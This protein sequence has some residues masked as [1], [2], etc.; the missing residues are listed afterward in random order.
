MKVVFADHR[1]LRSVSL[2]QFPSEAWTAVA[3]GGALRGDVATVM[4]AYERVAWFQR[5]VTLRADAIARMPYR[6]TFRDGRDDMAVEEVLPGVPNF[7]HLLNVIE[8]D[9]TLFGAAYLWLDAGRPPRARQIRRMHPSAIRPRLDRDAGLVGFAHRVAGEERVYTTDEIG[10]IWLPNRRYDLGP[11]IAPAV[12]AVRAA[13]ILMALDEYV[14]RFFAQGTIS[15]MVIGVAPE[16]DETDLQRIRSWFERVGVGIRNA[17]RAIAIRGGITPVHLA[18][19]EIEKLALEE[20]HAEKRED[21]ATAFGI[22]QSILFSNAA[23]Y[24]TAQQDDLHFYDKTII[25]EALLIEQ[26]LNRYVFMPLGATFRFMPQKL[27]VFQ[28]LEAQKAEKVVAYV[29]AGIMTR[30][31]AREQIALPPRAE[32]APRA[33]EPTARQAALK[34]LTRWQELAVRWSDAGRAYLPAC[35]V[36]RA[37]PAPL[38]AALEGALETLLMRVTDGQWRRREIARV[39]CDARRS[40]ERGDGLVGA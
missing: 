6:V 2:G 24:A 20:L 1:G 7:S 40:V 26:A 19:N 15:P 27:E 28:A 21:I 39:F 30:D 38:R 23:N 32:E 14:E 12:A 31:E 13:G 5:A 3:G 35:P 4:Q 33:P 36:A 29:G 34:A 25:P 17:F 18:Q 10:H 16:T 9:L 11:G 8:G 22:P 37:V